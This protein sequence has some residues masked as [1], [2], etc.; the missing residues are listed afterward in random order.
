MYAFTAGGYRLQHH[1]RLCSAETIIASLEECNRAKAALDPN[2]DAV[3]TEKMKNAPKGCFL[4][5]GQ[6]IFNRHKRGKLDGISEPV[7][8]NAA[9]RKQLSKIGHGLNWFLNVV[10]HQIVVIDFQ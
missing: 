10:L 9:G 7:C 8:T 4:Y 6:W 3:S 1:T 2:A 5:K